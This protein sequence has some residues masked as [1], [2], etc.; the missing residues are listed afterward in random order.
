MILFR[1]AML[2]DGSGAPPARGSLLVRDGRIECLGANIDASECEVV[3]CGGQA[4]SPG[5]IDIH[6]HS[7]LQVLRGDRAKTDQGVTAEVVGNCGFSAFPC[8]SRDA[9]VRDFADPI[10]F[11]SGEPW[12]W[13]GAREY[14]Q[15][16]RRRAQLCQVESLVGHGTLRNAVAG[17]RQGP[18]EPA[19]ADRLEGLLRESLDA[20]AAGFSTGLMYAPGSSAPREELA[21]LCRVAARADKVYATHMCSYGDDL[22]PAIDEQLDLALAS[23]CRLQISHL[24]AAGRRNWDKQRAALDKLE[25]AHRDGI[26]V[27]FDCYPYLAGSTVLQQLLPQWALDGG[28]AQLLRRLSEPQTRARM[29]EEVAQSMPQQWSDIFI[30]GVASPERRAVVGRDVASLA[31]EAGR[32]PAEY[33]FDLLASERAQVMMVSFN[34]SES[35]LRELLSHPLCSVISDGVYVKGR[36]HPRLYGT[37]AS[38]LGDI[39]RERGWLSL[40]EAVHRITARPA[41]RFNI[42]GRGRLALGFHADLVLFDPLTVAGPA[43]YDA[44]TT[45]PTG[46]RMVLLNGRRIV[47]V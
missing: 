41:A 2:I 14:L 8:G 1:D 12:R 25:Q 47:P 28:V 3:E 46:I 11:G 7:D 45:P 17:P 30:A 4:L 29:L 36:P 33:A 6:S 32:D 21:R 27:A 37:F 13:E 22:L 34:Q 38:L 5:F 19:E 18:L 44:P 26:D 39:S 23:G 20:G 43:S 31:K 10:L 15:D 24:Q 42:A 35:N 40:S 9:D 16:A